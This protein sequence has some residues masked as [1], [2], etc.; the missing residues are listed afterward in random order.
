MLVKA[1]GVT[2]FIA[3]LILILAA[4]INFSYFILLPIAGILLIKSLIG[5]LKDLGSWI[6]LIA[7]I[8]FILLI[9]F[10]VPWIICLIGGILLIQKGVMSFL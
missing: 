5:K 1:L 2:D 3:G 4:G 10:Q 9:F 6:D 8:L 7:S